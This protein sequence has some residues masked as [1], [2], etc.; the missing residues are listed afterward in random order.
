MG[1]IPFKENL[2]IQKVLNIR[3]LE[4]KN[5]P[6]GYLYWTGKLDNEKK[7]QFTSRQTKE[8]K[9]IEEYQ[10]KYSYAEMFSLKLF[11]HG[12]KEIE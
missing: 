7:N 2:W 10:I 9:W 3:I 11:E 4:G 8:K 1:D 5:L 12:K 6:N